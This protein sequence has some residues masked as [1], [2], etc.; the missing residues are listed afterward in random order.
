MGPYTAAVAFLLIA[1]SASAE[2]SSNDDGL[3]HLQTTAFMSS[4]DDVANKVDSAPEFAKLERDAKCPLPPN[5]QWCTVRMGLKHDTFSMAVYNSADIVSNSICSTGTWEL[6]LHDVTDLGE[7][8]HAL[9]I[10]AN[11]GFYSLVLAAA[12]WNVTSF[13]PMHTNIEL[14]EASM[15][16]NPDLAQRITLNKFGLGAKDDHCNII[17]GDDNLGDGVSVCGDAAKKP[18]Q[19]GYHKRATIDIRRLDDVLAQEQVDH[20]NFVKMDVEGFECQVMAGGQ[21]LLS[22]YRPRTIQS[23][24]WPDMQGCLP[25][26]YLASFAKASYSVARDRAC[27]T[28]DL[29]RPINID[30]R[31]MCRKTEQKAGLSLLESVASL[32]HRQRAIVWLTPDE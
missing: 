32:G 25:Q 8:G 21:S 28:P 10:G 6:Q 16:A 27:S 15:C 23:E 20:I 7:P 18:V 26:D 2:V 19:A 29:S 4:G 30:N 9:D 14:I 12:G 24:V 31:Y 1:A 5:A 22:K 13:E 11:V 3:C 17:S